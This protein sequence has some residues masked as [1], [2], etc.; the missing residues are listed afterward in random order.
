MDSLSVFKLFIFC[1]CIG[2][3]LSNSKHRSKST[4]QQTNVQTDII[5]LKRELESL[6]Q[7]VREIRKLKD[8]I[9]LVK[10]TVN[11]QGMAITAVLFSD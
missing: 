6:K 4:P 1:S 7:E 3:I 10:D 11:N 9:Q 2:V 8:D 5:E